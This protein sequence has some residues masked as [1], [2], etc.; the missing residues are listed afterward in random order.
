MTS[1]ISI[2]PAFSIASESSMDRAI[3]TPSLI[4]FSVPDSERIT[5]RPA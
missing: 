5:L 1:W 3:V 4:T 2:A